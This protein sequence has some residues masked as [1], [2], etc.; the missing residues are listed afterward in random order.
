M[1]DFTIGSPVGRWAGYF[2]MQHKTQLGAN[3]FI[4]KVRVFKPDQGSLPYM[5]FYVETPAPPKPPPGLE[6][7]HRVVDVGNDS[8]FREI[9]EWR[10]DGR[11]VVREH[12]LRVKV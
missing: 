11:S 5:L 9:R 8:V 6:V 12:V 1:T 2:L 10:K 3:K 7:R 4:N